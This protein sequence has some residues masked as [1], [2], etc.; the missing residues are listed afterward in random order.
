[1]LEPRAGDLVRLKPVRIDR[2]SACDGAV[3]TTFGASFPIELVEEIL[4][5]PFAIGDIVRYYD[6]SITFPEIRI[7]AI[8]GDVAWIKWASGDRSV[9]LLSVL[10]RIDS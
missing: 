4:P 1:M 10:R 3:R 2:I 6:S 7:L 5:R 9:A 8:D